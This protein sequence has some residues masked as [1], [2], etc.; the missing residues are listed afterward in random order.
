LLRREAALNANAPVAET[1][2]STNN[3]WSDFR[4]ME[5]HYRR[6]FARGWQGLASYTWSRTL[7][8][9]S[10]D[11]G[12]YVA[13]SAASDRGPAAFDARHNLSAGVSWQRGR[14]GVSALTYLRS[15]FPIDVLASEN[16]LGL[17]FDDYARPSL[18]QGI[19]IWTADAAAPGRRR[20]NPAAFSMPSSG[21]QG[22]LARDAI[23]G[24][25]MSQVDLACT[26]DFPIREEGVLSLR[27][28]A[29]NASN[30]PQF[31]DPVR[32]LDS[33]LFGLPVSMLNLML[34][35]GAPHSGIAPALQ[36]GGPRVLQASVRFRF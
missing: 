20:L 8:N 12:L 35:S 27:L 29:Y 28:E 17:E 32:F 21:G 2:V 18:I 23:R 33:P 4:G 30:H 5:L 34:G 1:P 10:W 19:P 3:G 7:D 36:P 16:L 6:R 25:G 31:A 22:S 26:R 14:W 24:F 13:G 15:S 11:S 9:G